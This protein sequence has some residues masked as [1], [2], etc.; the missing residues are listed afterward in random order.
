MVTSFGQGVLELGD[1]RVEKYLENFA[2]LYKARFNISRIFA[3]YEESVEV[4][5][6]EKVKCRVSGKVF[7]SLTANIS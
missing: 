3:E 2:M 4:N 5:A 6:L 7:R 1:H